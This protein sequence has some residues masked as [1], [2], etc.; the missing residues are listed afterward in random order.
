MFIMQKFIRSSLL[1]AT[2]LGMAAADAAT[3]RFRSGEILGAELTSAT[4][5]IR[6]LDP[7]DFPALPG[8]RLYA[9]L[10]FR[11]DPGRPVSIFDYSLEDRNVVYPCVA[12]NSGAGFIHT[13][14]SV[15]GSRVVQLLFVLDAQTPPAGPLRLKCN[16]PP[17]NGIYDLFVPFR[18]LGGN[19]PTAPS[20]LPENGDMPEYQAK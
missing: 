9:A 14:R 12:L 6:E 16:L 17:A 2:L 18:N 15:T 7:A 10:S 8:K 4:V 20:A 11:P 1:A 19:Y 3:R 5:T 13:D